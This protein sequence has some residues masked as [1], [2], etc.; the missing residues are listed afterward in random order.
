MVIRLR[1][2][3]MSSTPPRFVSNK[4]W[5]KRSDSQP[6][7]VIGLYYSADSGGGVGT[8]WRSKTHVS[9]M[10]LK[11]ACRVVAYIAKNSQASRG[12][13]T[14]HRAYGPRVLPLL[15]I[16]KKQCCALD[17]FQ[18]VLHQH[19]NAPAPLA[20]ERHACDEPRG[21]RG[22]MLCAYNRFAIVEL[23]CTT[24]TAVMSLLSYEGATLCFFARMKIC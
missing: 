13:R 20:V 1:P 8:M 17:V 11:S 14:H 12:S 2:C 21:V 5:D 6:Q 16:C 19:S 7:L 18:L 3:K 9:G 10:L 23:Q 24:F 22:K 4:S 15:Y